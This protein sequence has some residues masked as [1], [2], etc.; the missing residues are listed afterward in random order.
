MKIFRFNKIALNAVWMMSEK[1]ISIFGLIFVTSSVAKYVGPNLFGQIALSLSIFQIVQI[2]AQMG[3]GTIIF[4][5]L[6][7]NLNS[8]VLLL[9][10]T[11]YMRVLLYFV[12]SIPV[13]VYYS[14]KSDY[15]SSI[16]IF[17]TFISCFFST[18][19]VLAIYY[20]A[21][22]NSKINTCI[23]VIGLFISLLLRWFIVLLDWEPVYLSI[24]IILTGFIPFVIRICIFSSIKKR[25]VFSKRKKI[26][27]VK[28]LF[29]SGYNFVISDISVALY[30]RLSFF[31]ISFF[32]SKTEVGIYSVALALGN[33]WGFVNSSI[34]SSFFTKIYSLKNEADSLIISAKLN[35]LI[36][37]I[38]LI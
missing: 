6:S 31:I 27:Y 33:S 25:V 14:Y 19:D 17:A 30:T 22:L 23:N 3:G 32:A 15:L 29:K 28:Y 10:A 13:L 11:L 18:L 26:Q 2:I 38:G 36:F 35:L 9:N 8:G 4:K 21:T 24:P 1:I 34:I 5:R 7:K 16:F 37:V 20:D 12:I